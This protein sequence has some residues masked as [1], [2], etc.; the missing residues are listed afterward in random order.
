MLVFFLD[1]KTSKQNEKLTEETGEY[2]F[3]KECF[4]GWA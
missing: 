3:N 1:D 4:A 2:M